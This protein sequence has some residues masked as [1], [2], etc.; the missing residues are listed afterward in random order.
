M[1]NLSGSLYATI[2]QEIHNSLMLHVQTMGV[3]LL[4]YHIIRSPTQHS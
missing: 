1:Y 4:G 3:K 2:Y